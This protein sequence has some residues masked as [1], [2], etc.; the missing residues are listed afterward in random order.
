MSIVV[1]LTF[2][3]SENRFQELSDYLKAIL[4]DTATFKGA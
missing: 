4:P 2:K 1:M 3:A